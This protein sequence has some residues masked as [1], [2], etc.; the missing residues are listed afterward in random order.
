MMYCVEL[1]KSVSGQAFIHQSETMA[2]V[3]GLTMPPNDPVI[4]GVCVTQ[5]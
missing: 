2:I 3:G 4:K 5:R 1:W